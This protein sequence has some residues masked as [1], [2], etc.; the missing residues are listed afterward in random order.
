MTGFRFKNSISGDTGAA[1]TTSYTTGAFPTTG[2][3]SRVT[4]VDKNDPKGIALNVLRK[5][6]VI[7][8]KNMS[9]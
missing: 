1:D 7:R 8:A 3:G 9:V 2:G 4:K 6:N 5:C